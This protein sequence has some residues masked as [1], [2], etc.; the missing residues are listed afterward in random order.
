MDYFELTELTRILPH[1]FTSE[2]CL[3]LCSQAEVELRKARASAAEA[4]MAELAGELSATLT[5]KTRRGLV[6]SKI[7]VLSKGSSSQPELV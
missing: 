1:V 5:A 7:R 3:L 4:Q 6:R 2:N